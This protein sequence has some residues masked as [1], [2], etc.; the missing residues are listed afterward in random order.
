MRRQLRTMFRP[1]KQ[2]HMGAPH[3]PSIPQVQIEL[4]WPTFG[5]FDVLGTNTCV[6]GRL[7]VFGMFSVIGTKCE[8]PVWGGEWVF[9]MFNV[10]GPYTIAPTS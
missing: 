2:H 6:F 9:G 8:T 5:M 3:E 7:M 10:F 4:W 1:E